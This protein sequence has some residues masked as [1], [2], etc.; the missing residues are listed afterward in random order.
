MIA[1]VDQRRVGDEVTMFRGDETVDE[2]LCAVAAF[3][4]REVTEAAD[5]RI[6]WF[7]ERE[8][9]IA[10]RLGTRDADPFSGLAPQR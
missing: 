4:K 8:G 2:F 1:M 6:A 7:H 5:G 9:G 3:A 10:I